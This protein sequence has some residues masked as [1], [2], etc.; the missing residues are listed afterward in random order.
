MRKYL[1]HAAMLLVILDLLMALAGYGINYDE[2]V[3]QPGQ[4]YF[5]A[6][7]GD[8]GLQK[9]PT[10]AC[11]YWRGIGTAFAIFQYGSEADAKSKCPVMLKLH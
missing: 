10:L 4:S 9:T 5:A 6:E 7:F 8:L 11:R 1:F 2:A 3:V